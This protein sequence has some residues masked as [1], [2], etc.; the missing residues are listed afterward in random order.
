[1]RLTALATYIPEGRIDAEEIIRDAGGSQSEARVFERLFGLAQV[2]ACSTKETRYDQ[3]ARILEDLQAQGGDAALPDTLI[4]VRGLPMRDGPSGAVLPRLRQEFGFLAK[5]QQ[6]FD[7]DQTNCAGLIW[8]LELARTLLKAGRAR[9]VAVVAGDGHERLALADRYVPGSTLMGDAFC[10]LLLTEEPGAPSGQGLQIGDISLTCHPRFSFGY[11]GTTAQMGSFYA[12][13]GQIVS[14]TLRD[15]GFR[16]NSRSSLL[17]HNVNRMAWASFCAETGVS[18]DRISLGLLPDVGHCYTVDPFLL[19]KQELDDPNSRFNSARENAAT[20]LSVGMG[21]YAAGC[22]VS[23][24]RA[25]TSSTNS[26]SFKR[27]GNHALS[28]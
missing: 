17:P 14:K 1:M 24:P 6:K 12:A 25:A 4:H 22:Q 18:S 27:S 10:G 2:S 15:L 11:K 9:V 7:L 19:L 20:L 5:V 3:F 8:A 21:G 13:H 28:A 26:I 23:A 16:L